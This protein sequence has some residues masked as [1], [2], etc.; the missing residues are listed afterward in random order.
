MSHER[1][2]YVRVAFDAPA[3]LTTGLG[4]FSVQ[5]LDLSLQGALLL[6]GPEVPVADLPRGAPC[7]LVVPL[8]ADNDHIAMSGDI[9]HIEGRQAGLQCRT[10]D[11]DSVTHL[12]RVIE[13]QLGDP[14]LL[15]RDLAELIASHAAH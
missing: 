12:R 6:L 9:V 11:L 14:A 4:T 8:S 5:V 7:Q 13:L 3:L 15:E 1:R 2:H 10:M